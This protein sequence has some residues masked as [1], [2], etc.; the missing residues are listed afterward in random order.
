[1]KRLNDRGIGHIVVLMAVLVTVAIAFVGWHMTQPDASGTAAVGISKTAAP[2]AIKNNVELQQASNALDTT[3]IDKNL[4]TSS[5]DS[6][7]NNLL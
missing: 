1:M 5:L 6:A 4:D 2:G 3:P 7:V